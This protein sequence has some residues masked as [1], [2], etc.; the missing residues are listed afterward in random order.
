MKAIAFPIFITG[1]LIAAI[2]NPGDT[3]QKTKILADNSRITYNVKEKNKLEGAYFIENTD[4]TI[5]MRGTYKDEK[6]SGNWYAFNND[7]TVFMRYNYDLK[8]L[9]YLDTVAIK[10]AE[11]SITDK[12]EEAAKNASVPLPICSIDQYV[13]I[14][15]EAVKAGFPKDNIIYSKPTDVTIV[16]TIKSAKDIKYS[17]VYNFRGTNLTFEINNKDLDLN[18]DWI[19]S[20]YNGKD[21]EAE[22]KVNTKI[23]FDPNPS[24]T[25]RFKWNY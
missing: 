11:I 23:E 1:A 19:P 9:L 14:M 18:I 25:R 12:N 7:K 13:S 4:K 16:A 10:K 2:I 21:V 17:A 24:Q 5:W 3:V 15:G 6:K 20:T 8:K 22:F